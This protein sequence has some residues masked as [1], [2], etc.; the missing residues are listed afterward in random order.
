MRYAR[1]YQFAALSV[2]LLVIFHDQLLKLIAF[3]YDSNLFFYILLA[4]LVSVYFFWIRRDQIFADPGYAFVPGGL[5]VLAGCLLFFTARNWGLLLGPPE[6][7]SVL[8][9][10]FVLIWLGGFIGIWGLPA[11][12]RAMFSLGFLFFMIPIPAGFLDQIVVFL[13]KASTEATDVIFGLTGLPITRDGFVFALSNLEIEVA[14]Q[15]SG[16]RSS[17]YLLLTGLVM[18]QFFLKTTSRK[19]LLVLAVVPITIFKNGLRIA[20]LSLLGNYVHEDILTSALHSRGGIPFMILAVI[21]LSV[22]I[23]GLRKSETHVIG[24]LRPDSKIQPQ[25]KGGD[26]RPVGP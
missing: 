5:L 2:V 22:V 6:D 10:A 19:V 26:A 3:A 18:G 23:L 25:P 21:L 15:C 7:L 12:R 8:T 16:I 24:G 11:G 4:P 14:R 17:L 1:A 13:Q 9:A 20:T